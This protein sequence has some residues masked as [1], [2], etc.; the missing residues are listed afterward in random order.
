MKVQQ[1]RIKKDGCR[2][3]TWRVLVEN[4]EFR[5]THENLV[6]RVAGDST[7]EIIKFIENLNHK[8]IGILPDE[9]DGVDIRKEIMKPLFEE[10]FGDLHTSLE[11]LEKVARR[12]ARIIGKFDDPDFEEDS[13]MYMIDEALEGR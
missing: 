4:P 13:F 11:K 2:V 7:D 10:E 5:L 3:H 12:M 6:Y 8:V 9:G 1:I